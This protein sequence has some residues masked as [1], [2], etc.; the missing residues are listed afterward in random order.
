MSIEDSRH[1]Q[2]SSTEFKQIIK[3]LQPLSASGKIWIYQA[4][5][6]FLE[7][8]LVQ[9]TDWVEGFTRDWTSHNNKVQAKGCVAFSRFILLA[10]NEHEVHIG[11]C[12]ID[13]S[14]NFIKNLGRELGIDFF[15][16]MSFAFVNSKGMIMVLPSEEF[17][18]LY[19]SH[20]INDDTLVFNNLVSSVQALEHS[21]V[22]PLK[23]SWHKRFV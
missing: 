4:S 9:V 7:S 8:E 19:A 18:E 1:Y 23:N 10:A 13:K 11:G 12:S 6:P 22:M 5:R 15:D 16:R 14:V 21:W 3:H 17:K 20:H 2:F